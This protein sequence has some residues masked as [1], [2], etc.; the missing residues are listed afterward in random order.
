M[1]VLRILVIPISDVPM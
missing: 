1:P